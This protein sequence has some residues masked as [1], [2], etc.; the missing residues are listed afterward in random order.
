MEV[1]IMNKD[2]SIKDLKKRNDSLKMQYEY[3]NIRCITLENR[4]EKYEQQIQELT[5]NWNELEEWLWN[6]LD[7]YVK[8]NPK[9]T[10][11]KFVVIRIE[12]VLD[13]MKEIKGDKE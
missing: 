13:K 12:D 2:K 1:K 3:R 11:S 4:I 10:Y 5:N 9:E 8:N 6:E 7:E